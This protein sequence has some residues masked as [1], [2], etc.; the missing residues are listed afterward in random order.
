MFV[1]ESKNDRRRARQQRSRRRLR[2]TPER[3]RLTVFRSLRFIYAQVVDDS[4]GRVLAAASSRAA[5]ASSRAAG[6]K[7]P[8]ADNLAAA[9]AVGQQIAAAAKS[10]GIEAVVFDRGG[11]VYHGRVRALAEAAREAGLRF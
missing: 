9:R 10:A 11:Y 1:T 5:A 8:A 3:P 7:A 6:A 4:T 2:G